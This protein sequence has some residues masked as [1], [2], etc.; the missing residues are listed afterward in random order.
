M[1]YEV[2]IAGKPVATFDTSDAALERVREE[3][4]RQPDCE[5]EIIDTSTGHAF[6]PAASKGSREHLT[7]TMR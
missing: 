6:E 3:I 1:A 2:R 5:P 4:G 7:K